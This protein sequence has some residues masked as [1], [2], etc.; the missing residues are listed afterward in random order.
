MVVRLEAGSLAADDPFTATLAVGVS[1]GR[2]LGSQ[3]LLDLRYTRQS[4]FGTDVGHGA[5]SFLTLNWEHAYGVAQQYRRQLLT[6]FGAGALIR[7]P[8]TIAPLVDGGLGLRYPMGARW[9]LIA[10]F[11]DAVALLP[12]QDVQFCGTLGCSLYHFSGTVQQNFGLMILS[13][14]RL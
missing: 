14:W 11:E 3:G 5:R 4:D 10:G 6:H 12:S 1:V 13:E 7:P 8:F 9:A 2:P